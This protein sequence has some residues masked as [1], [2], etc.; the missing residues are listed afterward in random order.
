METARTRGSYA[1]TAVRRADIVKA[2]RDSFAEHGFNA[3]SLRDIAQRAG[4]THA[5]LLYH[6]PSKDELLLAVLAARDEEEQ[7]RSTPIEGDGEAARQFIQELLAEHQKFPD[8]MRLWSELTSAASRPGHPA[9]EYFEERYAK[10]RE[11]TA[12]FLL[13]MQKQGRLRE[14]INPHDGAVLLLSV[15]DGLQTQWLL[16]PTL[17]IAGP[18]NQFFHLMLKTLPECGEEQAL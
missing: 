10:A 13:R 14:G 12:G 17:D 6:Y 18:L 7:Q 1:K 15:L 4:M 5:S 11:A 2:A 16:E 3:S 8:V 9:Q